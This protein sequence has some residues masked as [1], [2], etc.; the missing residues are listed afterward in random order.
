MTSVRYPHISSGY[1]GQENISA[2]LNAQFYA[3]LIT[4]IKCDEIDMGSFLHLPQRIPRA[5]LFDEMSANETK[6]FRQQFSSIIIYLIEQQ[7]SA[8]KTLSTDAN[9]KNVRSFINWS[10]LLMRYGQLDVINH[11]VIH[12]H[13]VPNELELK[14]LIET[15]NIEKLLSAGKPI[16]IKRFI[17]IYQEYKFSKTCSSREMV[18][19]LNRI[20]VYYYRYRINDIDAVTISQIINNLLMLLDNFNDGSFSNMIYSSVAF[21]GLAMVDKYDIEEQIKFLLQAELLAKNVSYENQLE[22][23]IA[24]E[25]LY[26]CFQSLYKW[27]LNK[28]TDLARKYLNEIISIDPHDSTGHS[29]QGLFYFSLDMHNEAASCFKTALDLG[30][31]GVAL[32]AYYY[33]KCLE[34][35]GQHQDAIL[36]LNKSAQLDK[37]AIS[38]WL[39]L[40]VYYKKM[41]DSKKIC[42]TRDHILSTPVLLEQL[43]ADEIKEIQITC[44]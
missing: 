5:G 9:R 14:I 2:T 15:N 26:T 37:Q 36:H 41:N 43:E 22:K 8:Y 29:E 40:L 34:E 17:E 24:Q 18:M 31:P 11:Q 32:N 13:R 12:S 25:N 30:P 19:L 23:I 33:A 4:A 27:Y 38:P 44:Y 10:N 39:D 42:Q 16:S 7:A 35:L 21:R 1:I 6:E 3:K 20:I 28:N